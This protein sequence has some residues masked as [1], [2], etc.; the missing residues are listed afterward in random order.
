MT[1]P[2]GTAQLFKSPVCMCEA[3]DA[4][5]GESGWRPCPSYLCERD[6]HDHTAD[7]V[8]VFARKVAMEREYARRHPGHKFLVMLNE[9]ES[10]GLLAS[11]REWVPDA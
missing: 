3:E 7:W 1:Q 2:N 6:D 8:V 5:T 10:E 4:D 11:I 9:K